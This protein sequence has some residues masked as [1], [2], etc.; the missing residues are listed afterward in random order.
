MSRGLG[1]SVGYVTK[2]SRAQDGLTRV[3]GSLMDPSRA[4]VGWEK[5]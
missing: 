2:L 1:K 4:P 5:L 3:Q